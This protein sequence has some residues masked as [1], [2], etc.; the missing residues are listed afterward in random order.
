MK[1]FIS[2]PSTVHYSRLFAA[3]GNMKSYSRSHKHVFYGMMI[4]L[5][6]MFAAALSAQTYPKT[7]DHSRVLPSKTGAAS[8]R[9]AP[10]SVMASGTAHPS[11]LPTPFAALPPEI[12]YAIATLGFG[13]I[14]GWCVGFTLKKAAKLAAIIVGIVFMAIQALAYKQFLSIDWSKVKEVV[15]DRTIE[16]AWM[17]GMSLLTYNFPFAGA[18]IAGFLIGFRKG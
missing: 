14:A 11:A 7:P 10:Q 9:S 15:P 12:T 1:I 8:M 16:G 4:I 18:F 5:L 13:G 3:S 6:L 2:A 17:G